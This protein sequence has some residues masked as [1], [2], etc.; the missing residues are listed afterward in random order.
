MN[1]VKSVVVYLLDH[2]LSLYRREICNGCEVN[3][4]SQK[5][6]QCLEEDPDYF[7]M[8]N[9]S[10]VN[11]R[12]W[13]PTLIPAI[14]KALKSRGLCISNARITGLVEAF[15]YDLKFVTRID[16][17]TDEALNKLVGVNRSKRM[18]VERSLKIWQN[19]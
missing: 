1:T 4:S 8:F 5:Q 11:K 7:Y 6:H 16:Q 17:A 14:R 2:V 19:E 13:K 9:F 3:H 10:E 15:L 18:I 12:L